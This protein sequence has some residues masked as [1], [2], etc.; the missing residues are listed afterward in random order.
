MGTRQEVP[1]DPNSMR[2]SWPRDWV[3]ESLFSGENHSGINEV[4]VLREYLEISSGPEELQALLGSYLK[5][6]CLGWNHAQPLF[7]QLT[8]YF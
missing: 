6:R 8:V 7:L 4:M 5:N 1:N 3:T 2:A